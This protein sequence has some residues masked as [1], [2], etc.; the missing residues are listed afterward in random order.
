MLKGNMN[1]FN[2]KSRTK[3]NNS[4]LFLPEGCLDADVFKTNKVDSICGN[5]IVVPDNSNNFSNIVKNGK[6]TNKLKVTYDIL[7]ATQIEDIP[8]AILSPKE[9]NTNNAFQTASVTVHANLAK[10]DRA[11]NKQ[12]FKT[13]CGDITSM[14]LKTNG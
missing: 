4:S 13:E 1:K 5:T 9:G 3:L 7:P 8:G 11:E 2:E 10:C 14:S 12:P 6:D